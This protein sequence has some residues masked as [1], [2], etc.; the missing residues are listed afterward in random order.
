[1]RRLAKTAAATAATAGL[2]LAAAGCGVQPTGVNVA[3]AGPFSVSG[4][5]TS[6]EPSQ[7]PAPY[8]MVL[9]FIPPG[10]LPRQTVRWL[11]S[12]ALPKAGARNERRRVTMPMATR[13][14]VRR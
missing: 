12:R 11:T 3:Q 13:G 14:G 9:Y 1:M 4:S 10:G 5:S 2:A 6:E 7:S 8:P